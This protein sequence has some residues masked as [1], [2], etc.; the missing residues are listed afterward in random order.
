MLQVNGLVGPLALALLGDAQGLL[1]LVLDVF[2]F[3]GLER[4][5]GGEE[6]LMLA[7]SVLW[8]WFWFWF[9]FWAFGRLLLR[10]EG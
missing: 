6:L 2:G 8:F 3:S 5:A 9:W 4:L 10:F 1:C 7:V